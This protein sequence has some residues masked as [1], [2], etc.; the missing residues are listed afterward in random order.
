M[1]Q[2]N[3]EQLLA[4]YARFNEGD[5]EPSLDD[6]HEDGEY[7][8]SSEDPDSDIHR[9][10]E[11][12]RGSLRAGLRHIPTFESSRSKSEATGTKCSSGCASSDTAR[13]AGCQSRWSWRTSAHGVTARRFVSSSTT[14]ASRHSKPWV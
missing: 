8:A 12:I 1:S 6:W 10:I 4:A 7:V 2:E 9:G 11:A 5:K 3:V 14:I 13:P